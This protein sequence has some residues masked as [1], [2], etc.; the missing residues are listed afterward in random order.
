[1][2]EPDMLTEID[3]RMLA[4][5]FPDTVAATAAIAGMAVAGLLSDRQWTERFCVTVEEQTILV[6]SRLHF[7]SDRLT[8]PPTDP[9]WLI[10]RAL[11]TRSTNGF[12][13]QRAV[14]DL[15]ADVRPWAAPYIVTL[16]GEYVVEILDDIDTAL[17]PGAEQIIVAFLIA[18]PAFWETIKC[19]VV[20]Y[21]NVY[22]RLSHASEHHR[23]H[24][25][26]DYVGFRLIDRLD[27]VVSQ[28]MERKSNSAPPQKS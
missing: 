6:P 24:T 13:R 21:W 3:G 16:I 25:K 17:T 19:R 18:N 20:S 4:E 10:A 9:A 5:G 1:M 15:M 2:P 11:Q 26:A 14:Q 28:R 8:L 12:E 22:Y 23:A 7:A 27:R